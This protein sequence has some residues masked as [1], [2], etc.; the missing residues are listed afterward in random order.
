[1]ETLTVLFD[2]R[3]ALCRRAHA[4]LEAQ[5]SYVRLEFIAAGSAEAQ[6]RYPGLDHAATLTDLTVVSDA[7]DVYTGAAGWL[8]CLWALRSYRAWALTLSSPALMPQAQRFITWVA[9]NRWRLGKVAPET[10]DVDGETG[11]T[12]QIGA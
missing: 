5:P 10:C 9:Q 6:Q 3:C 12:C 8:M 4:W 7:G 1:M 11:G 2:A